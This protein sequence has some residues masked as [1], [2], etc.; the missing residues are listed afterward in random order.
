MTRLIIQ[1][2]FTLALAASISAAPIDF[3]FKDPK[4]VNNIVFKTDAVVESINGTASGISGNVTFDP[5]NP[6]RRKAKSSWQRTRCMSAI[7]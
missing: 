2:G 1:I 4:G 3:D 5:E 7:R 6:A